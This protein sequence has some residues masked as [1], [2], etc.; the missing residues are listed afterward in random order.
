M[1]NPDKKGETC[2]EFVNRIWG[3]CTVE[4]ADALL[5]ICTA[6]PC[7]SIPH[8]EK[9]LKDIKEQSGGNIG[10]AVQICEEEMEVA[11]KEI[12][13]SNTSV[14]PERNDESI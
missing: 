8:I 5:W 4:E 1:M 3:K 6:Y 14:T 12:A 7:A 10:K 11:M 13:Q 2:I 9:Q